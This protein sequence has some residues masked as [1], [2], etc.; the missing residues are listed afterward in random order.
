MK[1]WKILLIPIV[2]IALTLAY[3]YFVEQLVAGRI[4][5]IN[6]ANPQKTSGG[7]VIG[8]GT[9]LSVQVTREYLF[10]L[11]RLPVYAPGLGDISLMHTLFFWFI[12]VLAVLMPAILLIKERRDEYMAKPQFPRISSGKPGAWMRL[13]KAI[14][15]GALFAFVAYMFSGDGS[16]LPLGLLVAYMEYR[17][18]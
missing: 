1:R 5:V 18:C 9:A 15:I 11:V 14:G 6:S 2:L 7:E 12:L 10:G 3:F 8:I 4:S 17:R 13:G 16:S